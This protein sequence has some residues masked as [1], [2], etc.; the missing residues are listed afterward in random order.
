MSG[1]ED[2]VV[3]V[4]AVT[5]QDYV[6]GRLSGSELEAFEEQLVTDAGLVRELE[7]ALR[8]RE[9]LEMLREQKVLGELMRPRRRTV[10]TRFA[11][12]AAAVVLLAVGLFYMKR[13]EPIIAGSVAA[14]RTSSGSPLVVTRSHVFAALRSENSSAPNLDLPATGALELCALTPVTDAS[15]T[16]RMTLWVIRGGIMSRIGSAEHVVPDRDGFVVIYADAGR[17]EPGEYS[18]SVEPEAGNT[19]PGERFEFG[20]HRQVR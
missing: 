7:G 5:V 18:L 15:R 2:P 16:F 20:L 13:A 6:T 9:G 4:V 8:L 12:A 10:W 3:A 14:L 11:L 1:V 19:I 17:L